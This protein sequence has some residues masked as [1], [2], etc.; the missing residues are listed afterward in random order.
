M[1]CV[2]PSLTFQH[3]HH[4]RALPVTTPPLLHPS[5]MPAPWS[6]RHPSLVRRRIAADS[7]S[8]A[9]WSWRWNGKDGWP[10]ISASIVDPWG[11]HNMFNHTFHY[12]GIPEEII[13]D[14][15]PQFISRFWRAV[16][17]SLSSGYHPQSNEQTEKKIQEIG[18]F[19]RTFCHG[20]QHSWNQFLGWAKYAQNFL[21]QPST[22]LTLF[23]CVLGNQPLSGTRPTTSYNGP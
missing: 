22:G 13:S 23:Q 21:R 17:V 2:A 14:R 1:L 18:R 19:L 20:H 4:L 12:F 8:N 15:S 6:S 5:C 11:H 10:R 7:Y 16:A 9:R 3:P